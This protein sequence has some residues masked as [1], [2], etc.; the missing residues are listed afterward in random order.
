MVGC[1]I[2]W[3]VYITSGTTKY[4]LIENTH[5]MLSCLAIPS[6]G[7]IRAMTSRK[8]GTIASTLATKKQKTIKQNIKRQH[9]TKCTHSHPCTHTNMHACTHIHTKYNTHIHNTHTTYAL[10]IPTYTH[11]HDVWT[12]MHTTQSHDYIIHIHTT[13]IS[14]RIQYIHT[15][16]YC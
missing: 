9:I 13:P 11:A 4:L 15:I 7:S 1:S 10:Y 6:S 14:S 2:Q 5:C 3:C 16:R 12:H 8:C